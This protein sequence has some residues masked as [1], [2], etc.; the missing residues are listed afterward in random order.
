MIHF[1]HELR[2]NSYPYAPGSCGGGKAVGGKHSPNVTGS[3]EDGGY[4][5][6]INGNIMISSASSSPSLQS[7]NVSSIILT[8]ETYNSYTWE[9]R[10]RV[11]SSL[12][13]FNGSLQQDELY[14]RGFLAR[15]SENRNNL[16]L[17]NILSIEHSYN[18]LAKVFSEST[19]FP[20][21][22]KGVV[23]AGHT[24]NVDKQSIKGTL[25]FDDPSEIFIELTIV[26]ANGA[27]G[28]RWYYSSY[29][30]SVLEEDFQSTDL[31]SQGILIKLLFAFI[32]AVIDFFR[33][34]ILI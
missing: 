3:V 12:R 15:F 9:I 10:T 13:H 31:G 32:N 8:L 20:R 21:C 28:N 16:D 6:I 24:S 33:D 5:F 25:L 7:N 4:E 17:S 18:K 14:F 1:F 22:A 11:D 19:F 34:L 29:N 23:A 27:D 26:A 2:C 30:I